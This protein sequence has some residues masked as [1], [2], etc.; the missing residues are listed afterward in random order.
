MVVDLTPVRHKIPLIGGA[1]VGQDDCV[2]T[3][4]K[5]R[6]YSDKAY[7]GRDRHMAVERTFGVEFKQERIEV[8]LDMVA[9]AFS[10]GA[11]G[12]HSR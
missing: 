6:R 8:T 5:A 11:S 7:N 9:A 10:A 4:H 3:L 12:G 1:F 2:E